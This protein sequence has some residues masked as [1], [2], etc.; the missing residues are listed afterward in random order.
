MNSKSDTTLA[1]VKIHP[2][3]IVLGFLFAGAVTSN[4]WKL[5]IESESL[6]ILGKYGGL[7]FSGIGI[8]ILIVA[9]S[10]MAKASTTIN[11]SEHTT[12]IIKSGIYAYSRN[13]IYLGWF[14]VMAGS[15]LIGFSV[16]ALI[17]SLLM[18]P[19]LYWAVIL[20]EEKYLERKFGEEYLSYKEKVRRWL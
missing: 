3:V 6:L 14:L 19:L 4:I 12:K 11:P 18:I 7:F 1:K 5:D 2:A 8:S 15:G 16:F 9:Y 13:P 10:A 17:L 20:E